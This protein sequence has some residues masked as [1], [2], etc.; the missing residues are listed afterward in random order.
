MIR[1]GVRGGRAL[2][3]LKPL[4]NRSRIVV[5]PHS[6]E[7]IRRTTSSAS[8][9]FPK[10]RAVSVPL[11]YFLC[12]HKLSSRPGGVGQRPRD[13]GGLIAH[14]TGRNNRSQCRSRDRA[15]RFLTSGRAQQTVALLVRTR[16][17][18]L[19][20]CLPTTLL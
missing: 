12:V 20:A 19:L 18:H 1:A 5:A 15:R 17:L 7:I 9:L 2:S 16:H 14:F 3:G 6:N 11:R 10:T 8:E 13:S 4:F